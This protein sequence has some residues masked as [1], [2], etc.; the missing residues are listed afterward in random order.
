MKKLDPNFSLAIKEEKLKVVS[1]VIS[2]EIRPRIDGMNA[3]PRVFFPKEKVAIA[4]TKLFT[5]IR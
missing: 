5:L 1:D 3:T 4:V 2:I